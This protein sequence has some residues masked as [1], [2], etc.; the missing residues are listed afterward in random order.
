MTQIARPVPVTDDPDTAGHFEAAARGEIAICVCSVEGNSVHPPRAICDRC[1]APTS[2]LTVAPLAR[3]VTHTVV[4]VPIHPAFTPPYTIVLV[5][6]V[7]RPEV[8]LIGQ[9]AGAHELPAGTPMR[10][11][12]DDV[13]GVVVP[14]WEPTDSEKGRRGAG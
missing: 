5:E 6:L 14:N 13:D 11:R 7:D 1:F 9:L 12:F 4:G 8:R 2:W 3:V 10:A